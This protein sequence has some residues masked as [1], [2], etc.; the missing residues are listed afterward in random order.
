MQE[1]HLRDSRGIPTSI[2]APE[3]YLVHK[4]GV[5]PEQIICQ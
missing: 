2:S 4:F 1:F 3:H 5:D